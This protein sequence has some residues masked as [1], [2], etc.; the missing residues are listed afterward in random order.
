[1]NLT[2]LVRDFGN[3]PE[4]WREGRTIPWEEPG[5]SRRMLKEHLS[6]LHDAASR[7]SDLI[8]RHIDFIRRV[9]LEKEPARILDLGCGPGL[10]CHRLAS[11]GHDCTGIDI[12]PASIEYAQAEATRLGLDIRFD[13]ADI[14]SAELGSSFDLVMLL[15]GELN[16]FERQDAVTILRR[17]SAALTP[18]GRL[19]LEVSDFDFVRNRGESPP[20]WSVSQSGLFSD[21]PY[22]RCDESFW[23]EASSHAVG[24]HWIIDAASAEVSRFG[25]TMR[26]YTDEEYEALLTEAGLKLAARYDSLLG[27]P[28]GAGLPVLLA[29]KA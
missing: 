2:D 28:N 18:G 19:L 20:K 12:G 6:Q 21:Q 7:R 5:F 13:L 16:P 1:V 8:D 27:E 25:W 23:H 3:A 15:F 4:P 17:C 10:Y 24:R 14:R 11:L 29:T 9:A 22:I 26:A